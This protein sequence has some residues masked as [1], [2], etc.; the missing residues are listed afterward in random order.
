MVSEPCNVCGYFSLHEDINSHRRYLDPGPK[1]LR[2]GRVLGLTGPTGRGRGR[3]EGAVVE[4]ASKIKIIYV[5][6]NL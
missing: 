4:V 6:I 2:A 5:N 1:S 3:G